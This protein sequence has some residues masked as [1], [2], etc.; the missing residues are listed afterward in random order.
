M[1]RF[2]GSKLAQTA[3]D[4]RPMRVQL[5]AEKEPLQIASGS[6]LKEYQAA[7]GTGPLEIIVVYREALKAAGWQ[8]VEENT[9]YTTGDPSVTAHYAKPPLDLWTHVHARGDYSIAVAD[10][11]GER[12]PSRLKAELDKACKVAIY[13]VNFDFDQA[14]LR[15]DAEPALQSILKLLSDYPDLRVELGGHTDNAGKRDHNLTLSEGRMNA[16]RGWLV[17]KGVAADRL[18]AKGYADTQ[19]LATD[20]SPEARAK[21]R[22]VELRSPSCNK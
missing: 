12:A 20:D 13:G 8:I 10:A 6:V 3:Q 18:S 7:P 11:G 9:A 16:A 4:E 2:P 5:E 17:G 22:R 15:P 19:P 14:S 1:K 21:N